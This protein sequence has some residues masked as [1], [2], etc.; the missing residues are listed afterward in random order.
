LYARSDDAYLRGLY[1]ELLCR[2]P[3][4]HGYGSN[5]R[6]LG[7]GGSRAA[8]AVQLLQSKEALELLKAKT[9]LQIAQKILFD[10]AYRTYFPNYDY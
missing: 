10:F 4:R 9:D 3:D 8:L 7:S 1:E 5:M 2:K 6:F